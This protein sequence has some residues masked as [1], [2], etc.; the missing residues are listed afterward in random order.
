MPSETDTVQIP[1]PSTLMMEVRTIASKEHRSVTDVLRDLVE[2]ALAERRWKV[3]QEQEFARARQF[4]LPDDD[5]PLTDEYRRTIGE[6]IAEGLAS[7]RSG[8][9]VDGETVFTRVFAQI[10]EDERQGQK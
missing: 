6:K 3:E 5:A 2:G 9:L 4:G 10:D 8:R 7:A 1:L